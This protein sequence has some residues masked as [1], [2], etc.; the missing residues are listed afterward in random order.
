MK[1]YPMRISA[2]SGRNTFRCRLDDS[3]SKTFCLT[4]CLLVDERAARD[5]TDD[6][7]LL[8]K[9]HEALACFG[10]PPPHE[11]YQWKKKPPQAPSDAIQNA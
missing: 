8:V 9:V 6:G 10:I 5:A 1:S 3:K 7:D 2:D 11:S 4:F